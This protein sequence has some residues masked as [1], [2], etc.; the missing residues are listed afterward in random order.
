MKKFVLWLIKVF[1]LD[2]ITE[3]IVVKEIVRYVSTGTINGNVLIDGNLE[4]NV[5]L[6]VTGEIS[7]YTNKS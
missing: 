1:K 4:I 5:R 6:I 7:C 2:I 3:R